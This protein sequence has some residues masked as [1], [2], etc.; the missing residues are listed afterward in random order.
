[1][2]ECIACGRRRASTGQLGLEFYEGGE[3]VSERAQG[4]LWGILVRKQRWGLSWQGRM[5]LA[6]FILAAGVLLVLSIH[7]F[8]AVTHRVNTNI[9]VVEGWVHEFAIKAAVKEFKTGDYERIYVTGGPDVGSSHYTSDSQATAHV[10]AS[11][12]KAAGIAAQF[13][14]MVPS[15]VMTRDRT[16]GSAV[17]LRDWFREQNLNVSSLNV[18]TEDAHARRTWL[19]FQEA[20][21]PRIR[22]GIV[23]VPNPDYDAA[24][25][26]RYSDGVREVIGESIAYVYARLFF[27]PTY[28]S[29]GS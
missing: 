17:A 3:S 26:W 19:L 9:L 20:L 23:S 1:M 16:Y 21:G 4:K 12:L 29:Y 24:H 28:E 8:L 15:R 22:V 10:G 11:N 6:A 2:L 13:I 14:Q 5:A 7:P 27:W 25:W 18:L